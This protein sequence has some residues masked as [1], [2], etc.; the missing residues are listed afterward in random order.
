[1]TRSDPDFD[2]VL[3]VAVAV[4]DMDHVTGPQAL[5]QFRRSETPPDIATRPGLYANAS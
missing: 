4:A 5:A 3:A 2:E 1:M